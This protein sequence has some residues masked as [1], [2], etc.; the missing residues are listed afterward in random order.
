MPEFAEMVAINA[1]EY[2]STAVF[3]IVEIIKLES[4][5]GKIDDAVELIY[6]NYQS[7]KEAIKKLS[8]SDFNENTVLKYFK[9]RV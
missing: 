2:L 4:A 9:S 1:Y 8:G 5:G 6:M 3:N 7:G